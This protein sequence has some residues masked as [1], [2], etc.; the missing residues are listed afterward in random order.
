MNHSFSSLSYDVLIVLANEMD[1]YGNLNAESIARANLS[2]EIAKS[3]GIPYIVTCGWAYRKDSTVNISE[4]LKDYLIRHHKF[5]YDQIIVELN[6]R[7][8]VGDAVFTRLNVA[9][10]MGFRKICVVTSSYHVAR[11]KKIFKFVYG[12]SYFIDVR[13]ARIPFD[14]TTSAHEE[15][16]TAAFFETFSGIK[17]GA[18]EK[19]LDRLKERHPFYNGVVF[20]KL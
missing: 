3:C 9:M 16:S 20:S 11:A 10:K 14:V 2:A 4:A 1:Q 15:A 19:I 6:S 5:S 12:D 18:I 13:G 8:T 17:E 7:D